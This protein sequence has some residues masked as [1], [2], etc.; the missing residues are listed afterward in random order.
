MVL[1]TVKISLPTLVN[2]IKIIPQH[3]ISS[4]DSGLIV[5]SRT[6]GNHHAEGM[7]MVANTPS[8]PIKVTEIDPFPQLPFHI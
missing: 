4:S 8:F 3:P 5:N 6:K 2:S 1:L 7:L